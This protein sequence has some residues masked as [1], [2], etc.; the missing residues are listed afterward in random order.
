MRQEKL[1][2]EQIKKATEWWANA[3][4]NPKFDNGD[5]SEAGGMAMMLALINKET[6]ENDRIELFKAIF[7]IALKSD[8]DARWGIHCDYGPCSILAEAM[9]DAGISTSNAPW[10]TNMNFEDDKVFVSYGYGAEIIEI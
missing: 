6:V 4:S 8:P 10:K 5:P 1:T 3:I 2:D 7:A 9:K